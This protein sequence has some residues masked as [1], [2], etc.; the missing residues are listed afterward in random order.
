M[1]HALLDEEIK[2]HIAFCNS[3]GISTNELEKTNEMHQNLA[4][5][6][7]VLDAGF[8]GDF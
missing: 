4:Y 6:R 2:L 1:V 3:E 5:T 7:F 8:S